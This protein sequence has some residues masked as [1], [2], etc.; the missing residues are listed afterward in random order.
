[1]TTT[2]ILSS[3]FSCQSQTFDIA[4]LGKIY[5]IKGIFLCMIK[6][7]LLQSWQNGL[8]AEIMP[9]F[10]LRGEVGGTYCVFLAAIV[11]E[12]PQSPSHHQTVSETV[13]AQHSAYSFTV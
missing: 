13:S 12:R 6:S 7:S 10:F 9:F 11:W 3:C 2:L 8:G 1:M 5:Q 4:I